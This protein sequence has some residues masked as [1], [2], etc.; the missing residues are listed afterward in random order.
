[1]TENNPYQTPTAAVADPD[2][3][4]YGEIRPLS[5]RGRLGRVRYIA[6]A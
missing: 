5:P 2:D 1:M 4:A 6:Y 3:V